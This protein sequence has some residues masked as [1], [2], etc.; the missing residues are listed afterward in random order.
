MQA[1][2]TA[3]ARASKEGEQR[4]G[5]TEVCEGAWSFRTLRHAGGLTGACEAAWS[6]WTAGAGRCLRGG[7]SVCDGLPLLARG[8]GRLTRGAPRRA[9]AYG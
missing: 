8:G 9:L 1:R 5:E 4:I 2:M 7:G 6:P 3:V